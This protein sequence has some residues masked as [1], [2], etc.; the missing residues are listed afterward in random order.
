[1]VFNKCKH[2]WEEVDSSAKATL[3]RQ[4]S[5]DPDIPFEWRKLDQ[6][7][8]SFVHY[9]EGH[10]ATTTVYHTETKDSIT[11]NYPLGWVSQRVCLKCGKCDDGFKNYICDVLKHFGIEYEK[12]IKQKERRALAKK[13]FEDGCKNG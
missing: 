13:M 8:D 7:W 3:L 9:Y 4:M 1:M 11:I 10:P 5:E 6:K 12:C 2:D